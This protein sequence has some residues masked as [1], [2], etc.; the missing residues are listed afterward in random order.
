MFGSHSDHL[1]GN[2]WVSTQE[3]RIPLGGQQFF[4]LSVVLRRAVDMGSGGP[5]WL[6]EV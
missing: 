1:G 3:T 5:L 2:I 4:L 6:P